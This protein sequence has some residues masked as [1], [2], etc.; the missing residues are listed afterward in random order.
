MNPAITQTEEVL[1][2]KSD[3]P[4]MSFSETGRGSPSK[5]LPAFHLGLVSVVV[6]DWSPD[7]TVV[8]TFSRVSTW[9]STV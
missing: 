2:T 3:I 9:K 7:V 6:T 5:P 1:I 4:Y 8:V